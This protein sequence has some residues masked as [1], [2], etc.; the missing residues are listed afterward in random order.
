MFNGCEC[1]LMKVEYECFLNTANNNGQT[2]STFA[3]SYIYNISHLKE[4]AIRNATFRYNLFKC[5]S[6]LI[7]IRSRIFFY[8]RQL[9]AIIVNK[10]RAHPERAVFSWSTNFYTNS[11]C[12]SNRQNNHT[13]ILNHH[14]SPP[15]VTARNT[16]ANVMLC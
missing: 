6:I 3:V 14:P 2:L 9:K 4:F 8:Q 13:Y 5:S 16:T 7:N 10:S 12:S 11:V 1:L 15:V